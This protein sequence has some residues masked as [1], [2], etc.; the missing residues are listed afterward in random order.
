MFSEASR[1]WVL[2]IKGNRKKFDSF[3]IF[4]KFYIESTKTRFNPYV[5]MASYHLSKARVDKNIEN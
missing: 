4:I 1:N 5:P 2:N 3:C